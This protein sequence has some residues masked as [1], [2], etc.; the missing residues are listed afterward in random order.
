MMRRLLLALLALGLVGFAALA[1]ATARLSQPQF[2][3][4]LAGD[5]LAGF[6]LAPLDAAVTLARTHDEA[7][8]RVVLV[9]SAEPEG[10]DVVD[11]AAA[12]GRPLR[13]AVDAFAAL[14]LERLAALAARGEKT[15]VDWTDLALPID[16]IEPHL[17]AGT[18]FRA[19]AEEVGREEGPFLFPKLSAPTAW[20]ADVASRG[21][22][23]YE[24]ELCA[25]TLAAHTP[26]RPAPLGYVLCNDFTDRWTLVR[27]I[28][29]DGPMGPT[30]FPDGKGGPGMLPIGPLLVVPR[31]ADA[32]YRGLTLE[33]WV[34]G[35][36]HQRAPASAMIWPPGEILS[37]ALAACDDVY[38]AASG[39]VGLVDCAGLPP[40]SLVLT[41]TPAGVLF[42]PATL[43]SAGAYLEPGDEVVTRATH[44]GI[45]RNRIR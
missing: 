17:A 41:G 20:N 38:H 37:R 32:F 44:L 19:H 42:H 39:D 8:G 9:T 3:E 27:Q 43:W 10:L 23:D 33:L 18:N 13:D 25:V 40:R 2:D 35:A 24:A 26:E 28:D 30:G 45:L 11:L 4:R 5:P 12:S 31:D 34:D 21:R 15:R 22:F 36:L 16:A 14:G 1:F 29:L 7:G 6:T